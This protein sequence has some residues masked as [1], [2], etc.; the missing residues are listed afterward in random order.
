VY[1]DSIAKLE[2]AEVALR[3]VDA[4][5]GVAAPLNRCD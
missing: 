1:R 3:H 2:A 5:V 4:C